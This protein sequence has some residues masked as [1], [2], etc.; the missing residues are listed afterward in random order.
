MGR[1][2]VS[3][4]RH[5][6]T[7]V[8][9]QAVV[10]AVTTHVDCIHDV[11]HEVYLTRS[12][13]VPG[14]RIA[15]GC[16][17]ICFA[18]VQR[19]WLGLNVRRGN[20]RNVRGKCVW[21]IIWNLTKIATEYLSITLKHFRYARFLGVQLV[22]T[23]REAFA[24]WRFALLALLRVSFHSLLQWFTSKR[25]DVGSTWWNCMMTHCIWVIIPGRFTYITQTNV[26]IIKRFI[27]CSWNI[28][29]YSIQAKS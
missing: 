1:E 5:M 25:N 22:N 26:T 2:L 10:E 11:I 4:S 23:F 6:A 20:V 3:V 13:S 28:Y 7:D 12:T 18:V 8:A 15:V 9:L 16:G 24:D 19:S 29:K 14:W 21:W 27:D 17:G